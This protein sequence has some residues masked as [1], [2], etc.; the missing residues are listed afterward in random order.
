MTLISRL[1]NLPVRLSQLE[2]I[3]NNRSGADALQTRA[4]MIKSWANEAMVPIE[5][6]RQFRLMGIS[7]S[8]P[9]NISTLI[10]QLQNILS[11]FEQTPSSIGEVFPID[12]TQRLDTLPQQLK[13]SLLRAWKRYI[14]ELRPSIPS[15][16]LEILP[17][18][19]QNIDLKA[20]AINIQQRLDDLKETLPIEPTTLSEPKE[21][22]RQL[23]EIQKEIQKASDYPEPVRIFLEAMNADEATFNH[24]TAEVIIWLE[25]EGLKDKLS[26]SWGRN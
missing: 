25:E 13:E 16:L 23:Q 20:R 22:V 6:Y 8:V 9:A 17:D 5:L 24:L 14:D 7:V 4:T 2:E 26:L 18:T 3:R 21:L 19:N 1:K 10:E 11:E 12:L 15:N